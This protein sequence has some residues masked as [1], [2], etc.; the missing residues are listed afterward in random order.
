MQARE[1][2]TTTQAVLEGHFV[3]KSRRH[4]RLYVNKDRVYVFPILFNDLCEQIADL[5]NGKMDIQVVAGPAIGAALIAQNVAYVLNFDSS[6][7]QAVYAE[8]EIG[9]DGKETG[10][11]VF[12]RGYA[13]FV[14]GKNVLVVEDITTTGNSAKATVEAVRAAGGSVVTVRAL[15]NRGGVTAEK[16][17]VTDFQALVEERFE[18]YPAEECPLCKAGTPIN[19][20]VGHGAAYVAEH[21]QPKSSVAQT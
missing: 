18:D 19:T 6:E 8:K 3:Y 4:G 9:S 13:E 17:G 15:W 16:L 10:R 1:I 20:D 12:K 2:F 21:G 11:F 7:V 5:V 14:K